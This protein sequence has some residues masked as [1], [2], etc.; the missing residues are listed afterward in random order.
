MPTFSL[1]VLKT[2][3]MEDLRDF[4]EALGFQFKE[5][6]HGKGPIHWSVKAGDAVFEIY[7]APDGHTVDK[8]TRIG[9]ALDDVTAAVEAVRAHGARIDS[10]PNSGPDGL[11]AIVRDP[12][13][14]AVELIQVSEDDDSTEDEAVEDEED[15]EDDEE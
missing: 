7:P 2:H 15:D 4:Y 10:K 14:R 5:E 13:G 8:S 12:D 1:V 6:Q 3:K 11:R 9:F